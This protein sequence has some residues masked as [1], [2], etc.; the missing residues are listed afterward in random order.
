MAQPNELVGRFHQLVRMQFQLLRADRNLLGVQFQPVLEFVDVLVG[1]SGGSAVPGAPARNGGRVAAP[2][3]TVGSPA[4][5]AFKLF[6]VLQGNA[7]ILRIFE[8][9]VPGRNRHRLAF[10]PVDA[11]EYVAQLHTVLVPVQEL[12]VHHL[13]VRGHVVSVHQLGNELVGLRPELFLGFRPAELHALDDPAVLLHVFLPVQ[14][15]YGG[16]AQDQAVFPDRADGSYHVVRPD[17]VH[18]ADDVL[19]EFQRSGVRIPVLLNPVDQ[20]PSV[21]IRAHP[22][23]SAVPVRQVILQGRQRIRIARDLIDPFFRLAGMVDRPDGK[24]PSGVVPS[25]SVMV[26][27]APVQEGLGGHGL[28]VRGAVFLLSVRRQ[29]AVLQ[30]AQRAGEGNLALAVQRIRLL[31]QHPPVKQFFPVQLRCDVR[32]LGDQPAEGRMPVNQREL[33]ASGLVQRLGH[34]RG[35]DRQSAG[36]G[37]IVNGVGRSV[38]VGGDN[39]VHRP[40]PPFR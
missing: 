2:V 3:L 26:I 19:P 16:A 13:D 11:R 1:V 6:R 15:D 20:V 37:W 12:Q 7:V 18:D 35:K 23:E 8:V 31:V 38:R 36:T 30:E 10:Q 32:R 39:P 25:F 5:I 34:P 28:V 14:V 29:L 17:P 40:S 4:R 27:D 33:E 21:S 22:E 9:A 24:G